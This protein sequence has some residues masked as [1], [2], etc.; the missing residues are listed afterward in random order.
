MIY[1]GCLY[2][3]NPLVNSHMAVE[4]HNAVDFPI[5]SMVIFHSYVKLPEGNM[6][7]NMIN[8][9]LTVYKPYSSH[10]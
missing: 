2:M 9:I 7:G 1:G 10:I 5:N 3:A 8:H 6:V 4:N